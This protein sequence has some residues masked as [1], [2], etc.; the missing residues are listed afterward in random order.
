LGDCIAAD[1][2]GF[3]CAWT[4]CRSERTAVDRGCPLLWA[5]CGHR[6]RERRAERVGERAVCLAR[7]VRMCSRACLRE[8]TVL[9]RSSP[10]QGARIVLSWNRVCLYPAH[11]PISGPYATLEVVPHVGVVD[12]VE[13]NA[14]ALLH[15]DRV[16][17]AFPQTERCAVDGSLLFVMSPVSL[18][19]ASRRSRPT[20]G[21]P[22][23]WRAAGTALMSWVTQERSTREADSGLLP[24]AAVSA[25]S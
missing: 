24:S 15:A 9:R 10:W 5:R 8:R 22:R 3:V 16:R 12:E 11:L 25:R 2:C 19:G 17:L 20:S 6:S 18:T 1:L 7:P 14:S 13:P 23:R 4:L 21:V